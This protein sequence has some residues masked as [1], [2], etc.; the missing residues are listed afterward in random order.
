MEISHDQIRE[1]PNG[2][3]YVSP[4]T[5]EAERIAKLREAIA[6]DIEADRIYQDLA[7]RSGI[8]WSPGARPSR[9]AWR[10][11]LDELTRRPEASDPEPEA[12]AG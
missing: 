8:C 2:H 9:E 7:D 4:E 1:G 5:L 3:Y 11:E 12:E 6:A 10:A